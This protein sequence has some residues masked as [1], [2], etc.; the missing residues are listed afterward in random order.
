MFP[1][2]TRS[3]LIAT[4]KAVTTLSPWEKALKL[5]GISCCISLDGEATR[6]FGR[7]ETKG[8]AHN[9]DS[10]YLKLTWTFLRC[11]EEAYVAVKISVAEGEYGGANRELQTMKELASHQSR[12]KHA[13][14]MLD[15]FDLVGPNGVHKCIVYELLGPNVPD[16]IDAHFP[17]GRLPGRLAKVIAKQSLIGLD[18]LHQHN[19][20][21]GGNACFLKTNSQ[22]SP[23]TDLHTRNLAFTLPLMDN[24]TEGKFIEMLGS[25]E[26]GLVRRRDGKDIEPGIPEYMVKPTSYLTHTWDSAQMIKIIDFGESFLPTALPQTLH[27]PLSVRAPEVIFQD[28]IDHR[29]DLWSM[30]CMVSAI[31]GLNLFNNNLISVTAL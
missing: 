6:Q 7:R 29:A 25:P 9:Y 26:I 31:T 19:I 8:C 3:H 30:G 2:S 27:T 5:G 13:V 10:R 4:G 11:S 16:V 12:L 14:Q 28:H 24:L 18:G 17:G 23:N 20:G 21:H 15:D 22:F 1:R